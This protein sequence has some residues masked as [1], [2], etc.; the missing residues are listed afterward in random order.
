M[1]I[2]VDGNK[3]IHTSVIDIINNLKNQLTVS[4]IDKLSSISIK[5]KNI[6]VTC[7]IHSDGHERTPSCDI[8]IE[9]RDGVSAGTVHCFACG[10]KA[11]IVKF[12][13]DCLGTS[14]RKALE[15]LL[16]ISNY[17]YIDVNS[18]DD[19]DD[20]S[21]L[22]EDTPNTV[23]SV[24]LEELKSYD[25][26]HPY[27]FKRK[28]TDDI[29]SKYEIGYDPKL[30]AI[31]FPVYVNGIC[32]FVCKRSVVGKRFYMPKMDSKPIYG[33]H[34]I[35]KNEVIVCE[36]ILN[37]LTAISYGYDAI[38]LFGTGTKYQ[39]DILNKLGIRHFI[40]CLDG[41]TA[42]RMGAARFKKNIHDAFITDVKFPSNKDLNDLSEKEFKE[43]LNNSELEL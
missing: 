30:N 36:S 20:L 5:Q 31:T 15:W 35:T 10:Y 38:A 33:L 37:A 4:N 18:R 6:R 3:E 13:S 14:Y 17:T 34:Y 28:L 27:M 11:G 41:D 1:P 12:I 42:G 40:L 21:S 24:S 25:Y 39:Y 9:D 16:N 26:I 22:D 29:I 43:L 19:I 7:P 23:S 32:R 2:I 8:L